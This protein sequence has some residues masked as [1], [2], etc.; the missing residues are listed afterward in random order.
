[1]FEESKKKI[2]NE[3]YFYIRTIGFIFKT[4]LNVIMMLWK[5]HFFILSSIHLIV[6]FG[7]KIKNKHITYKKTSL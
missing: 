7:N 6:Y 5:V 1:M 3:N 4:Q 2:Q